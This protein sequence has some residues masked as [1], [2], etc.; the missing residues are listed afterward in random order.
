MKTGREKNQARLAI[1]LLLSILIIGGGLSNTRAEDSMPTY[2]PGEV[3]VKLRTRLPATPLEDKSGPQITG[4]S[5]LDRLNRRLVVSSMHRSLFPRGQS[6]DDSLV[7]R[8]ADELSRIH[9]IRMAGDADVMEAV[10]AYQQDP[11]VVYAQPNFL[12]QLCIVPDDSLYGEQWA[13]SKMQMPAAWDIE[14]GS[15]EVVVGVVDSGIDFDHQDLAANVWI[16]P[17]ED[18]NG[19]GQ[20]D[21]ADF[22]GVDDDNNGYVDDISGWDFTD[23]PQFAGLGDYTDRDNLADDDLGHGSHVSGIVAAVADNGVGVAGLCWH[24]RLMPLRASFRLSVGAFLEDDDVSAGIVYAADNGADVINMSWGDPRISPMVRDVIAYADA[25]GCVMAAAAGNVDQEGLFYPGGFDETIAAGASTI[26]DQRSTISSFGKNLDVLAPGSN[27]MST[28]L[29]DQYGTLGGTSMATAHVS[30]LAALVLSKNPDLSSEQV[31]GII[32]ASAVDLE[33]PGWDPQT[34]N[35]RID[36]LRALMMD[37]AAQV[38]IHHPPTGTGV[39]SRVAILGTVLGLS[40]D[41]YQLEYGLGLSPTS[42]QPIA[43]PI[44][45]QALQETLAVWDGVAQLPDTACTIRLNV[46]QTDGQVMEDRVVIHV[47]HTPPVLEDIRAVRRLDGDRYAPFVEWRTDDETLAGIHYRLQGEEEFSSV[48]GIH[49]AREHSLD[50]SSELDPGDYEY[51]LSSENAAGLETTE[52]N[53][54]Q[55]YDLQNPFQM[56][57]GGGFLLLEELPLGYHFDRPVDLDQDGR[58]ELLYMALSDTSVY[59]NALAYE[60]SASGKLEEAFRSQANY[61]IW[62]VGDSDRDGKMEILGGGFAV[63]YLFESPD[64]NSFPD[65]LTP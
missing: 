25:R 20:I 61:L 29:D 7:T 65:T 12:N 34:G 39:D 53:A 30:G 22:N 49:I 14:R 33:A 36:G 44:C 1:L 27:I 59:G 40:V 43:G 63:I 32:K 23:A 55:Y 42:F 2:A 9:L 31:R 54:G 57:D 58:Q 8:R 11:N 47:D 62:D 35:G 21:E 16:N 18:I 26:Y 41:C 4:L 15:E 51:Y 17:G 56:I 64:S 52:D 5:S 38:Q 28:L 10:R 6:R 48:E 37:Q 46:W 19:N 45:V 24:A 3:I 13:L 60:M 50:L